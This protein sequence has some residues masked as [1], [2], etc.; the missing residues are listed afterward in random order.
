MFRDEIFQRIFRLS[1]WFEK[2]RGKS[3]GNQGGECQIQT[4]FGNRE[5]N[6]S[7]PGLMTAS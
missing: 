3:P 1:V 7:L 5:N 4:K 2:N 6:T